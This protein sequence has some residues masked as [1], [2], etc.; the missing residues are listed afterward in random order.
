MHS[1]CLPVT[2]VRRALSSFWR[3]PESQRYYSEI[4]GQARN[5]ISRNGMTKLSTWNNKTRIG[6]TWISALLRY[7]TFYFLRG[8]FD[9]K[10]VGVTE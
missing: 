1:L 9:G 10:R 2:P 7:N 5:D 6:M 3:K 4:P 8:N